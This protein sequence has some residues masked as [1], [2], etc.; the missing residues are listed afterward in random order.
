[1][2]FPGAK[3]VDTTEEALEYARTIVD[4]DMECRGE[5]LI[6]NGKTLKR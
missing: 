5:A 1:M 2:N 4:D 3:N 6:N